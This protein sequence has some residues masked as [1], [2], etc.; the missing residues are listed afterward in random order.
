[1]LAPS[2]VAEV[3]AE[4]EVAASWR[5]DGDAGAR[6]RARRTAWMRRRLDARRA[7]LQ[8][9]RPRAATASARSAASRT[10]LQRGGPAA[11]EVDGP[12]RT[13]RIAS[14]SFDEARMK[15]NLDIVGWE[16]TEKERQRI[17]KIPQRKINQGRRYITEHGQYKSLEELWD[18]EI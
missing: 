10:A 7:R 16:L 2:P 5:G 17:S 18:G 9:V 12:A 6:R 13:R 15:E 4:A 14:K 3:E 8:C 1:M 11:P